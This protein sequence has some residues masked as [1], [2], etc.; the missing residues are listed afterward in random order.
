MWDDEILAGKPCQRCGESCVAYCQAKTSDL[1]YMKWPGGREQ[2]GYVPPDEVCGVRAMDDSDYMSVNL[3]LA[4]GQVQGEWPKKSVQ[5][6]LD[7]RPMKQYEF[8]VL[9]VDNTWDD[10]FI[11]EALDAEKARKAFDAFMATDLVDPISSVVLVREAEID[12]EAEES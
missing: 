9:W 8:A 1:F 5:K 11:V 6:W 2:D 10:G 4:C 3:C 12:E 7:A